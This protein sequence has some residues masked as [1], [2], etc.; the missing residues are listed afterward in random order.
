MNLASFQVALPLPAQEPA[1]ARSREDDSYE[2]DRVNAAERRSDEFDKAVEKELDRRAAQGAP[3]LPPPVIMPFMLQPIPV[4]T[5]DAG[6]LAAASSTSAAAAFSAMSAATRSVQVDPVTEGPP[7]APA[8]DQ[9]RPADS[10]PLPV[11]VI[12]E[13]G[14]PT[15]QPGESGKQ[16]SLVDFPQLVTGQIR[17][18]V[19]N[20]QPLTQLDFHISPPHVGPVNLTVSYTQ[21]VVGV[22]LTALTLQAKQALEGQ[23]GT[24]HQI[25]Q[26]HNLQPG[27]I[28]V[29]TAV[30]GRAGAN[31]AGKGGDA[32]AFNFFS[33][34]RR[35]QP[36]AEDGTVQTS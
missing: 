30:G 19:K 27:Q 9:A 11:K 2:R 36:G 33:G 28:K 13:P 7:Q 1:Q 21:G 31:G 8:T 26:A 16:V 4:V 18:F 5:G 25:L 17:Q 23:V 34:G 29:V 15:V 10:A 24:I 6:A 12:V 32:P 20:N 22:Q 14:L 3:P 35:K